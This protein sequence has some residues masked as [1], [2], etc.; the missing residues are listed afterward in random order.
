MTITKQKECDQCDAV[1]S[2]EPIQIGN[3][4]YYWIEISV[5]SWKTKSLFKD[6]MHFCSDKCLIEYVKSKTIK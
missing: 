5:V 3:A 1:Q 2:I 6:A 4:C